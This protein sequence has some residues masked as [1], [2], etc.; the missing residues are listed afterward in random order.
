MISKSIK[1]EAVLLRKKGYSY[2]YIYEKMNISKGTLSYW[3]SDVPYTPNKYTI[4]KIGK[5]RL[6]SNFAKRRIKLESISAAKKE[7]IRDVG[8]LNKRDLFMLGIGLYLGEGAKTNDSVRI[9]N[10]DPKIIKLAVRW[11]KEICGLSIS[12]FRVRLHLYP[13]NKVVDA[14]NFWSKELG[15]KKDYFQKIQIDQRKD[16]KK[17]NKGKLPFGT[18]HLSIVSNGDKRFGVYLARRINAWIENVLR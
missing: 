13:D 4:D 10:S 11:F 12:N 2:G 8:V 6:A 16:K 7:A 5:A 15:I 14:I 9:I 1:S 3:L 17:F 18:A